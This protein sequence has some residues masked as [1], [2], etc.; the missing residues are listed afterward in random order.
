[1]PGV[2]NP[3]FAELFR[4]L[5]L[6]YSP[7]HLCRV[8]ICNHSGCKPFW[9]VSFSI[10]FPTRS[11]I[12]IQRRTSSHDGVTADGEYCLSGDT[13][14]QLQSYAAAVSTT[15][16]FV[17]EF[18]DL[19]PALQTC[20]ALSNYSYTYH[21][22]SISIFPYPQTVDTELQSEGCASSFFNMVGTRIE[23][24]GGAIIGNP[25]P[26]GQLYVALTLAN[27]GFGRVI[28]ARPATLVFSSG[29]N[30]V[31]QIP[32][33]LSE[34]DLR[35]LASSSQPAPQTFQF[36]VTLP[37]TFPSSVQISMSLLIPD[38]A[39]SLTT[40]PA[41]ALPL[42]SLDQNSSPMFNSVTGYNLIAIFNAN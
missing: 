4:P 6:D 17:G 42:N 26:N 40:Q 41:Y 27:T 29:G 32:V 10:C 24:Q 34:L 20:A 28:R 15:T 18:G 11:S 13:A 21:P 1:M 8:L 5:E 25:T 7:M 16:M 33:P 37:A 39:P 12:Q 22:Q 2:M 9:P 23:L 14:N 31:A 35:Q 38:P 3:P 36:T 30:V 19:Y